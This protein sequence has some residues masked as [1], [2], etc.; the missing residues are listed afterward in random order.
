MLGCGGG[1]GGGGGGGVTGTT[2]NAVSF[3]G[4]Q[5]NAQAGDT[6]LGQVVD[7]SGCTV[8]N[9]SVRYFTTGNVLQGN[10][11]TNA[12]GY[13][14]AAVATTVTRADVDGT[15]VP[16]SL[17]K[18]FSYGAG[19]FQASTTSPAFDC[20]VPLPTIVPGNLT[21]MPNGAFRFA[22]STS[23]PPPPPLSCLP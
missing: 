3:T 21:A 7:T 5:T 8:P 22:L 13:W 23:P 11:I 20:K 2:C 4:G 19:S 1:G 18:G 16:N 17:H 9:I 6:I 12:D 15:T 10:A 14:R